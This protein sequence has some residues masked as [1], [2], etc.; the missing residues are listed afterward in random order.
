MKK[1][2]KQIRLN[3]KE[4]E[5]QKDFY[6]TLMLPR[7]FSY[8]KRK[9]IRRKEQEILKDYKGKIDIKNTSMVSSRLTRK[10]KEEIKRKER[11]VF[12]ETK[13]L[14]LKRNE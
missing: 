11:E 5:K 12:E 6:L 7:E 4:K 3:R 14:T 8:Y 10:Q 9:E 1:D 13:K 2:R